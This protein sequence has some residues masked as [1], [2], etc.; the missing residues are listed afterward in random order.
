MGAGRPGSRF[1]KGSNMHRYRIHTLESAPDRSRAALGGLQKQ[2]GFVPNLAAT[3]AESP[4]LIAGFVGALVNFV[5][6]TFTGRQRQVLLLTNAVT[7]RSVW[8]VAFHSTMA[9]SEGVNPEDIQA[10]RDGELPRDGALAALSGLTRALIEKRGRIDGHDIAAFT[11]AGF[12]PDQ[13]FEVIAGL[14]CSVM[15]NY[16]GNIAQPALEDQFAAWAWIAP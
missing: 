16:A 5:G 6:G 12:T 10:I 2:F 7:N 11:S 1:M 15:A 9:A 8:A 13:V 4:T 3:M 14:A